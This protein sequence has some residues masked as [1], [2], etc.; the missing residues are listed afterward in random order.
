MR[1]TTWNLAKAAALFGVVL[2][3]IAGLL[4]IGVR[5]FTTDASVT[6]LVNSIVPVLMAVFLFHGVFCGSEGILL[7][8]K[9]LTFLGRMYGAYFIVVPYLMMRVKWAALA[10]KKVQLRSVWNVFLG[11]QSFRIS[12]W[13]LRVVWLQHKSDKESIGLSSDDGL[14]MDDDDNEATS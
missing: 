6:A 11:Y 2:S 8:Q 12:A 14:K 5:L 13:V 3:S 9:D 1:Q 7:A 4:P 10:G